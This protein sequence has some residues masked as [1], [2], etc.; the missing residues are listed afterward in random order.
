MHRV[1]P[2]STRLTHIFDIQ[3]HVFHILILGL[4]YAELASR[5]PRAGSAYSYIYTTLGELMA[6]ITG[7][8]MILEYM[9]GAATAGKACSQYFDAMINDTIKG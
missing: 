5:V 9:I 1:A 4:C 2:P 6:F 7:W 3:G 8:N